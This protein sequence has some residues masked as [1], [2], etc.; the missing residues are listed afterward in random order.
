MD[1]PAATPLG[2]TCNFEVSVGKSINPKLKHLIAQTLV[3]ATPEDLV[4]WRQFRRNDR[5]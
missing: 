4:G 2:A 5:F 3:L 1:C